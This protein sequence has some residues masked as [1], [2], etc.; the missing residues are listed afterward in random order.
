MRVA[1]AGLGLLLAVGAAARSPSPPDPMLAA[2]AASGPAP[3]LADK[4]SLF[5]RLVGSWDLRVLYYGDDGALVREL[6]GEWHF[7]WALEGRA[8]QDV[9]I[10]PPRGTPK[11]ES[12]PAGG[13]GA[14][15]RFYDAA[16]DVWRSTW[17][18]PASGI[19][20]EFVGRK[21]GDEIVLER[22]DEAGEMTHWVFSEITKDGF[23]WRALGSS[24]GGK[25]WRKEQEMI[26]RRRGAQQSEAAP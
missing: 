21:V 19:V 7:G 20:W 18:S 4:L 11:P 1:I 8:I 23:R 10:V 26:A 16:L 14:T 25:T 22:T 15:L 12:P 13:Y 6:A 17:I 24:D 9:W 5:G 3:E 2:L